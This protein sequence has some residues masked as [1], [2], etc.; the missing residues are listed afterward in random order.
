VL[1]ATDGTPLWARRLVASEH[2]PRV[3]L[4]DDLDVWVGGN[5]AG[6]GWF[7][8]ELYSSTS[9]SFPDLYLASFSSA[10]DALWSAAFAAPG[11]YVSDVEAAGPLGGAFVTGFFR[12]T[13]DLGNGPLT[14]AG[15]NDIVFGRVTP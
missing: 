10:G 1:D 5:F 9:S 3:S 4:S 2:A 7:G 14:S 12:G 13:V 6:L 8:G 15:D 11:A